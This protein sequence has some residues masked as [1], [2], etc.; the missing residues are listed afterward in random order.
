[1]M[2]AVASLIGMAAA[3][4]AG[5][6]SLPP[7]EIAPGVLMPACNV[8]HPD[9][10]CQ[11]GIGPGCAAAAT[12]ET[13][14]WLRV[15]GRGVDTAFG[16]QNQPQVGAAIKQAIATGVVAN[17][18]AVFV[19]TKINPGGRGGG[20]GGC[21]AAA[22]LA[23]V[24]VD[25][26]QLDVGPLDLV[27]QH[28]P[29]S[30]DAG[31]QAVWEGLVQAKAA[32][33]ARAI[34]VSHAKPPQL[35]A[36]MKLGKGKPAVNQCEMAVGDHDAATMRF[37]QAHG[38]T[39][40]SYGALRAVDL[41]DK[42]LAA[43]AKAHGVTTAQ[44]ALRWVTQQGCPV[45]VS[46][47]LHEDYAVQDLGL[48]GFKLTAAE[49]TA[50]S[51]IKKVQSAPDSAERRAA[52]AAKTEPDVNARFSCPSS[53]CWCNKMFSN[54]SIQHRRGIYYR[55]AH[56][57]VTGED[58]QLF[59]DEWLAPSATPR[60]GALIIHGGGYSAG[61]Y[62]GC[63][64][65]R[66]MSSFAAQAVE[67]ARHGFVVVSI[68][69]RCEGSLRGEGDEFE[70]WFDAVED[71]RAAV[72][73][74]TANAARL[75]LDP[76]RIMAF[77]GSAGAVTVAQMLH[78]LPDG[79]PMPAPV[80]PPPDN[81]T[82]ALKSQCPLVPPPGYEACLSC[83]RQHAAAPVCRPTARAAYCNGT[84]PGI[85]AEIQAEPNAAL[86]SEG[87]NITCG[88]ALS[89]AITPGSIQSKQVTASSS[90]P[91]YLDF[92]G[93]KDFTVPYDWANAEGSNVTWGDAI[94]TK[95]WLDGNKAPNYLA[96]IPGAGHVPFQDLYASPY[97]ETFFGFLRE[98]MALDQVAC[99][100]A[101]ATA[102]PIG[103]KPD[104]DELRESK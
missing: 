28:F 39:Y 8:G 89:G 83:S 103:G 73:F 18:S 62:N 1:M 13:A 86:D 68:D 42:T 34:G 54:A 84:V 46:P 63:S 69:Y 66:N 10:G 87:G 93:T 35:E 95:I 102:S 25:V 67:L 99:P 53:S 24:E 80:P 101:I 74:M 75:R 71:A 26:R 49:M 30:T 76:G 19:T 14:L 59:L 5:P 82:L 12:N 98:A 36:I 60:P 6:I 47:G 41:T 72:R 43:A 51:A 91:P 21:T 3:A 55:T 2:G 27:L 17:R 56:N 44:V 78:A 96:S 4:A 85:R 7:F 100:A 37:C 20:G 50:I 29:C 92:H 104:H 64:H 48:G 81:C 38:I 70:P 90:S 22:T 9:D 97:Y 15:G 79:T 32:G 33:L 16:Y 65:A 94:D 77:G 11:H 23:A 61:P 31:N 45:A 88:I 58:Q 57:R 40:E 52:P